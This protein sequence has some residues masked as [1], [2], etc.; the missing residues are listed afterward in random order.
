MVCVGL[1]GTVITVSLGLMWNLRKIHV[2]HIDCRCDFVFFFF[3][4][5]R[6]I[7]PH[8]NFEFINHEFFS[9]VLILMLQQSMESKLLGSRVM[10]LEIQLLVLK[11]PYI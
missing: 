11:W 8:H 9:K 5:S 7:K 1:E 4:S 6:P 2:F 10:L 3:R